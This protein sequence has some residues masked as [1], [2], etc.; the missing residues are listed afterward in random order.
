MRERQIPV[1]FFINKIDR[2]GAD[3]ASVIFAMAKEL[4]VS[5]L[6]LQAT[7]NEG[8]NEVA[9]RNLWDKDFR[10]PELVEHVIER[11]EKLLNNYQIGRAHV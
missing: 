6:S 1:I 2:V 3:T 5:P 8:N 4:N 10:H 9:I 7:D 11:D